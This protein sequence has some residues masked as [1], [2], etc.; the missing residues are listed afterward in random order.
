MAVRMRSL[1]GGTA[2]AIDMTVNTPFSIR[3]CQ[4]RYARSFEPTTTGTAG[5]SLP[6]VSSLS[7]WRK[8]V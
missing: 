3:S 7:D 1:P 8:P 4:N 5:V 6:Q 2:G